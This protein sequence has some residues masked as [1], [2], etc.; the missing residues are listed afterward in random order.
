MQRRTQPARIAHI[1][2]N[3]PKVDIN[4][5]FE[6]SP[7]VDY[8][9]LILSASFQTLSAMVLAPAMAPLRSLDPDLHSDPRSDPQSLRC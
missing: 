3:S 7:V 2:A 4:V 5:L 9:C 1:G 8:R 6:Y